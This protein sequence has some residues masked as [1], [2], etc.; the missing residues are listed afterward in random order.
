MIEDRNIQYVTLKDFVAASIERD[1]LKVTYSIKH[2]EIE[3]GYIAI[4]VPLDTF[5][6]KEFVISQNTPINR[7]E[8]MS[9]NT[10]K[11]AVEDKISI[12]MMNECH[13]DIRY[14]LKQREMTL[15]EIE[16]KLG[17]K[18]KIVNK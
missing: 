8:G 5:R 3:S 16:E 6:L 7:M 2:P 10:V 12:E 18:V 9:F 15:D 13:Y 14:T 17:Y 11:L 4:D 1:V